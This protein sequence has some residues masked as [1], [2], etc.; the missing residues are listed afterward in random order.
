MMARVAVRNVLRHR[1]RTTF[2]VLALSMAVALLADMLMLSRGMEKTFY[3]VLSS[4]G[5]EVRVCPRGTL[6]FSTDAV[7]DDSDRVMRALADEPRVERSL[8]VLG[9]TLHADSIP[10]FV[11][12]IDGGR[13]SLYRV[14]DGRDVI[15]TVEMSLEP[16]WVGTRQRRHVE[17][18][19]DRRTLILSTDPLLVV[20]RRGRQRLT[21]ERVTPE[22]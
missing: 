10:L 12:G 20:G 4:V 9:T 7:I 19:D 15:H 13:Q 11:M 1:L 2:T 17:L 18:P 22:S 3:R 16:A 5:Y 14:I 6:P 21:W 8:R